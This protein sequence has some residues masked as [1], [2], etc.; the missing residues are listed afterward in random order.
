MKRKL[1]S[2]K[3]WLAIAAF[4]FSVSNSIAGMA[5]DNQA[6][7]I[8]GGICGTVSA[9]MYAFSEALVDAAHVSSNND[10]LEPTVGFELEDKESKEEN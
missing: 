4:L 10:I 3:L 9:A 5:T 1:S 2:R 6:L 7:V 8:L